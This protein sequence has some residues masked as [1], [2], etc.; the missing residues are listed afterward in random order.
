MILSKEDSDLFF[1]LWLPLLRYGSEAHDLHVGKLAR[2]E[3]GIDFVAAL[4]VAEAIWSD[5]SVIDD[6]LARR[7]DMS[8]E[9]QQIARGW[10][11]AIRGHFAL[12][13]HLRGGSIFIALE[14]NGVYLVKG[15][16]SPWNELFPNR[17]MPVILTTALLPFRG[18]IITDGLFSLSNVIVGP[19]IRSGLKDTYMSAKADGRIVKAL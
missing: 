10:K 5:V 12:E 2:P 17:V 19:G 16:T 9:E 15:I 8:P 6:Y 18:C 14:N 3:G 11:R 1:R 7:P 4:E 13:R